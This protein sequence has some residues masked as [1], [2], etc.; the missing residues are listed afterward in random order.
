MSTN[1]PTHAQAQLQLQ[2]YDLRR[3]AKLR[4]AREWFFQH[5]FAD[6]LEESNRLAPAGSQE[7]A[8]L[9]MLVSYWEQACALLNYGLLHEELFF[10]TSGEF[11]GVWVRLR[12]VV[13]GMREQFRHPAILAH[14]E[15]A[16]QRYEE[17]TNKHAP[18]HLEVMRQFSQQMRAEAAKR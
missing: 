18:G 6:N 9:R 5:Y 15:K 1:E 17:W 10:Q 2:L 8:Y 3:E 16:A 13:P 11:Y 14:M 12:T 4:Q 7:N